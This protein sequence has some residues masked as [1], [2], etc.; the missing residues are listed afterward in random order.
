DGQD[1]PHDDEPSEIGPAGRPVR[2]RLIRATP[3]SVTKPPGG[4]S[5]ATT[6]ATPANK[7]FYMALGYL[8]ARTTGGWP[9]ALETNLSEE[10]ASRLLVGIWNTSCM[11][12]DQGLQASHE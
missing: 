8:S 3:R 7:L 9:L 10:I 2:T 4:S 6:H 5:R 11:S 12:G 1:L